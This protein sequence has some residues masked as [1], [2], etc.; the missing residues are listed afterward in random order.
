MQNLSDIEHVIRRPNTERSVNMMHHHV[1]AVIHKCEKAMKTM[2]KI[3]EK[4][5][6]NKNEENTQ[7]KWVP[8]SKRIV[9]NIILHH[10]TQCA[11]LNTQYYCH[12]WAKH[13]FHYSISNN[14]P[15][16]PPK[17]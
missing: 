11:L 1:G 12:C 7:I 5:M 2:E 16:T 3:N 10:T 8:S 4:T 9:C 17:K 13:L 14:T 15:K 6:Q